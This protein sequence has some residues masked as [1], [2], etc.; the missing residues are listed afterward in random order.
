[1]AYCTQTD[2][3]NRW[4][5]TKWWSDADADGS[6]D[7]TIVTAA[8]ATAD[9]EIDSWAAQQYAVPLSLGNATTARMIAAKSSFLA[10]YVLAGRVNDRDAR[11]VMADEYKSVM[12]WLK[13]LAAGDIKLDGE[14]ATAT[15]AVSGRPVFAGD[16]AI[17]TR[18]EM[19]GL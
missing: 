11:D 7:S 8:I 15:D 16:S 14:T 19:D 3:T 17:F 1:M 12:A 6:I 4:S 18:D 2:V 13:Q 9:G 5:A 10:G